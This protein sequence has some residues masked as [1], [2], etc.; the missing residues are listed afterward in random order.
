[1]HANPLPARAGRSWLTEGFALYRRNPPLLTSATMLYL[2]VALGLS[3]LHR[4][5]AFL[6]PLVLPIM[7]V[8]LANVSAVLAR[9]ESPRPENLLYRLR[10][11]RQALLQ[12]GGLQL[13]LSACM[14]LASM[15][16]EALL[17]IPANPAE[18]TKA[19]LLQVMAIM[20]VLLVPV[21]LAFWFAPLL[22]AWHDVPPAKAI[23]FSLV[24]A[25]RNK[26]AFAVYALNL[27]ALVLM[28]GVVLALLATLLP[29]LYGA[30]S[31]LLNLAVVMVLTPVISASVYVSYLQV[32][33]VQVTLPANEENP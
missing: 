16:L 33:G 15:A 2:I 18:I 29:Q 14:V 9:G 31:T 24:A 7:A 28:A 23:F 10:E 12:L 1:M 5:L 3:L 32:F 8:L 26:G 17:G 19:D 11:R 30:V 13:A 6:V 22:V 20:F 4:V 27:V 21:F 25:W